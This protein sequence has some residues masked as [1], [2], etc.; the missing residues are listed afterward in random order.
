MK[1]CLNRGNLFAVLV[2]TTVMGLM[3]SVAHGRTITVRADGT[4][5]YPTIQAAIGAAVDGDEVVCANG[6]YTGPGNR[7]IDFLGKAITVRS[8]D[9]NDPNI[10]AAT[11]ID[12]NATPDDR[13][14]G[15]WFHN[16][17]DGNSVLDGLTIT[18]VYHGD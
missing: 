12:C 9:P 14:R 2:F 18:G 7:D 10:A 17:E 8:I 15:F 4:G 11:V 16:G 6:T 13:H 5:D 1:S 3:G